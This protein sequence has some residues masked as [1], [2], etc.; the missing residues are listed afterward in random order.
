[1]K[2]K[3]KFIP[4]SN[5]FYKIKHNKNIKPSSIIKKI[6]IFIAI[7]LSIGFIYQIISDK[8]QLKSLESKNKYV[9]I[10]N[11]KYYFKSLGEEKPTVIFESDIGMGIDQWGKVQKVISDKYKIRTFSYDRAGYGFSEYGKDRNPEEQAR[12]LRM[13][14]KK[15][16][17]SGPYILVGEGYGSILIS[18]FANLYPDLVSGVVLVNPIN[19]SAL[20]NNDYISNFKNKKFISKFNKYGSY[21]G[22]NDLLNKF[23]L[24]PVPNS[25]NKYFNEEQLTNYNVFRLNKNFTSAYYNELNNILNLN[26]SIQKEGALSKW[27]LKIIISDNNKKYLEELKMIGSPELTEIITADNQY[28]YVSLEKPE[29]I[30]EAIKSMI[31]TLKV[32]LSS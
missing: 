6:I 15:V 11:K 16:G 20:K 5:G 26:S 8:I 19:V 7:I 25:V 13:I 23:G 18:S 14:L 9:R 30:I 4:Y 2:E 31:D 17:L 10:D 1:M 32:Q 24:L 21:I 3:M 29:V 27:P 28:E 22:I 12:L